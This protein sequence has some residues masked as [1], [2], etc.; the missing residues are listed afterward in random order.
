MLAAFAQ[1]HFHVCSLLSTGKNVA[2]RRARGRYLLFA[3]PDDV[4]SDAL[5]RRLAD[6]ELGLRDDVVYAT[7]RGGVR[8]HVPVAEGASASSFLRY[9]AANSDSTQHQPLSVAH[10][11]GRW[12]RASC[13]AGEQASG[14]CLS[15]P[16]YQWHLVHSAV[17]RLHA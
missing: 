14:A 2:A 11:A 4:W 1:E 15:R 6:R 13:L 5:V 17:F 9:V 8:D 16:A 3:N 7:F 12:R 10:V